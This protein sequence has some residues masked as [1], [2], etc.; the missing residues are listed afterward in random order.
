[1][2][3]VLF[4]LDIISHSLL[5]NLRLGESTFDFSVPDQDLFRM[6]SADFSGGNLWYVS[7]VDSEESSRCWDECNLSDTRAKG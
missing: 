3:Q 1:M 5:Q 2:T 6:N 4:G 7:Q